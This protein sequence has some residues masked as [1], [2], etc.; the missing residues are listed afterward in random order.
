LFGIFY[1]IYVLRKNKESDVNEAKTETTGQTGKLFRARDDK[2]IGGVCGGLAKNLNVDPVIVRIGWVVL[3]LITHILGV[4]V[5]IIWMIVVPEETF[6]Q[7]QTSATTQP[8]EK[9]AKK[10]PKRVKKLP[11]EKDEK[12]E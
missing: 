10:T 12:K 2:V 9:S 1:L 6:E 5:Y 4:I 8:E 3:T 7:Q 11:E